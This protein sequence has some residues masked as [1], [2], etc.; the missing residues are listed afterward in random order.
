MATFDFYSASV[1]TLIPVVESLKTVLTKAKAFD[2]SDK[3][4]NARLIDDM[5]PLSAQIRIVYSWMHKMSIR[6]KNGDISTWV[7]PENNPSWDDLI[8]KVDDTLTEL[9]SLDRDT[10]NAAVS[11]K[12]A[13]G[14]GKGRPDLEMEFSQYVTAQVIPNAYFHLTTAYNICRK[15]GVQ[16]GK[17][18]F[19]IAHVAP[20]MQA[21]GASLP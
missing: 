21:Q 6:F 17:L 7:E 1:G 18:D 15:E 14:M 2:S 8:Q 19:I 5:L 3:L 20:L 16:L 13:V 12:V 9:K 4:P 11:K 10:V